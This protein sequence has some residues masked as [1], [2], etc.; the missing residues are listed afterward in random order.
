MARFVPDA[1]RN[2][3]AAAHQGGGRDYGPPAGAPPVPWVSVPAVLPRHDTTCCGLS[4]GSHKMANLY[5]GGQLHF[6]TKCRIFSLTG[7]RHEDGCDSST[8]LCTKGLTPGPEKFRRALS[9][10][11]R[12]AH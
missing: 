3:A 7:A 5:L 8:G 10:L 1:G 12:E 2:T 4:S 6:S 11:S 9:T